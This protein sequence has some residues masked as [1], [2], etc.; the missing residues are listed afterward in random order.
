VPKA[1]QAR[2]VKF[3]V[4]NAFCTPHALMT[5]DILDRVEYGGVASRVLRSQTAILSM[6][7]S[8][9]KIQRLMDREAAMG[10]PTY[11]VSQLV[12]D[13]QNGVWSELAATAPKVDICR[14]NL[15]RAYL[16]TMTTKLVG[17]SASQSEFRP[18][19]RGAIQSLQHRVSLAIA[20]THDT[21]TLLHLRDCKIQ[22][23]NILNP[24]FASSGGGGSVPSFF[25]PGVNYETTLPEAQKPT[26]ECHLTASKDWMKM[27][28]EPTAK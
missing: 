22:I 6:L 24:K 11:T 5:P 27:L 14:R 26:W 15:Q 16:K 28:L 1:Q 19:A 4:D 20:K 2:A 8:E 13:V 3:L 12:S 17:D 7:L 9:S 21:A 23:D 25:F 10:A 18:L